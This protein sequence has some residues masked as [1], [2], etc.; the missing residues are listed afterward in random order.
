MLSLAFERNSGV[1]AIGRAAGRQSVLVLTRRTL[2]HM[3]TETGL[4]AMGSGSRSIL[5]RLSG[6][7]AAANVAQHFQE[8][9][10]RPE[11]KARLNFPIELG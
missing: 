1:R 2:L 6:G 9:P 11:L 8:K 3:A 10:S 4:P 7:P 5:L